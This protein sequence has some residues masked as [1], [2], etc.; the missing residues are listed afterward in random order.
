MA[1]VL[2]C[3]QSKHKALSTKT[4]TVPPPKKVGSQEGMGGRNSDSKGHEEL[5]GFWKCPIS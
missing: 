2:E 1:Q 3:M 5:L 4:S